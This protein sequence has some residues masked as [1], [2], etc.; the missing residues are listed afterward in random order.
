MF[1]SLHTLIVGPADI[2]ST[3][4]F[5]AMCSGSPLYSMDIQVVDQP[6][7]NSIQRSQQG[8][9]FYIPQTERA[10]YVDP[11]SP[12]YRFANLTSVDIHRSGSA[13]DDDDPPR[14]TLQA[15]RALARHCP[16]LHVLEITL[17]ASTAPPAETARAWGTAQQNL[18][19]FVVRSSLITAPLSVARFLSGIFAHLTDI[20]TDS[21]HRLWKDVERML[22][23]LLAARAESNRTLLV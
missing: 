2:E 16:L 10:A 12:L 23:E 19:R 20:G 15:L 1:S 11:L 18:A 4:G 13:L 14:L 5:M 8:F 21:A 17:D 7:K 3:T 6:W 22:P 9:G